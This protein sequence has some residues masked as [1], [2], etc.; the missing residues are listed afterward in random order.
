MQVLDRMNQTMDPEDEAFFALEQTIERLAAIRCA[1]YK[2]DYIRRRILSRMRVTK[3]DTYAEYHTFLQSHPTEIEEL[4]NALTINVTSF[5]RDPEVFHLLENKVIPDL[6]RKKRR[7]HVWCAGCSSGEEAYSL[8]MAFHDLLPR[9]PDTSALIYASDIDEEILIRARQGT[10]D[11]KSLETLTPGQIRS[12]FIR[13]KNGRYTVQPHLK[14]LVR[15]RKHDLMSDPPVSRFLDLI[16]CR[17][18]TIYFTESQKNELTR[19]FHSSL[20]SE[21]YYVTGKTEYL[22]R[23]VENLFSPYHIGEKI[24]IKKG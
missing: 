1:C 23:D 15:F 13:E 6:L 14:S 9:C 16:T 19:M 8:A 5:F 20:C 3:K 2:E 11:E 10:Y 18:V 21:G 24:Y 22:G 17:N 7:I 4:K 12:H